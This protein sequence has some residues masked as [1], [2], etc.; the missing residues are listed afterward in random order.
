MKKSRLI[1]GLGALLFWVSSTF[2]APIVIEDNYWGG[3][4]NGYGDVI[5]A[6]ADFNISKMEVTQTGSQFAFDIYT[7]FAGKSGSLFSNYTEGNTGILYGDLFLSSSW[8]PYGAAGDSYKYDNASNGTLWEYGLV[9]SDRETNNGGTISLYRLDGAT[10]AENALLSDDLMK[11]N[12]VWR[13]GQEVMVDTQSS[14]T[15]YLGDIG[16][17]SLGTGKVSLNVD[18]AMTGL[19]S[20][21][22]MGFH[23][24]MTCGNDVI[25]G[26]L[27]VVNVSEPGAWALLFFGIIGLV[28]ARRRIHQ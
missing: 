14:T 1:T 4:D 13:N 17:W 24:D 23:W 21:S 26:Q 9:F 6:S 12:A 25:E 20:G 16:V 2:A 3:K 18:L 10:N 28:I 22:T 11:G 8:N 27:D 7:S 19:L 15:S 5:G